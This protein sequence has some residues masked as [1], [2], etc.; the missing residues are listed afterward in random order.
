[1]SIVPSIDIECPCGFIIETQ[2]I[3]NA[4]I[5]PKCSEKIRVFSVSKNMSKK[6]NKVNIVS[7]LESD[8]GSV[9]YSKKYM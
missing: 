3:G 5:C 1:M 2:L 9:T 4:F 6:R 8:K 7:W